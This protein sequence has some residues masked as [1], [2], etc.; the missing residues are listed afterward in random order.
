[1][2][3][4]ETLASTFSQVHP[5][6]QTHPIPPS[7]M[8]KIKSNLN[9]S[10]KL[11]HHN[12]TFQMPKN[13]FKQHV[14]FSILAQ[15]LDTYSVKIYSYYSSFFY[16]VRFVLGLTLKKLMELSANNVIAKLTISEEG[17]HLLV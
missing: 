4:Q 1:M 11:N 9:K 8:N 3:P 2:A 17:V 6:T 14:Y 10:K 15:N 7:K 12:F 13:H 5:N 16:W